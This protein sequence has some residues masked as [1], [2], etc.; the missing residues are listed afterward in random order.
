MTTEA[1]AVSEDI[2]ERDAGLVVKCEIDALASA[3]ARMLGDSELRMRLG[4]NARRLAEQRF[5]LR[6]MGQGLAQLYQS[7]LAVT[8][9]S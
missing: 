2:R 5:S 7:I 9:R 3:M 8:P 4:A 1:V 6:A